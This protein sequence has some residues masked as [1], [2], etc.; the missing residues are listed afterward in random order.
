MPFPSMAGTV[1]GILLVDWG[2]M[3]Q[4]QWHSWL[5]NASS[6]SLINMLASACCTTYATDTVAFCVTVTGSD[7]LFIAV[8][9]MSDLKIYHHVQNQTRVTLHPKHIFSLYFT[10]NIIIVPLLSMLGIYFGHSPF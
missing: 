4:L 9:S 8:F 3:Y 1:V 7:E 5:N 6:F 2:E 10:Y